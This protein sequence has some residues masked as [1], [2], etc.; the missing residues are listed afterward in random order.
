MVGDRMGSPRADNLFAIFGFNIFMKISLFLL[1][2]G[3]LDL[4]RGISRGS[5]LS[6][7]FLNPAENKRER[8]SNVSGG[9]NTAGFQTQQSP[10]KIKK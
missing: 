9:A 3:P 4:G 1:G 10:K 6:L 8:L 5:I 2:T 7:L